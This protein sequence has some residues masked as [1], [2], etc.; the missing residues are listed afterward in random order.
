MAL[1]G[2]KKDRV[3]FETV[4]EAIGWYRQRGFFTG[5]TGTDAEVAAQ[6]E[7]RHDDEWDLDLDPEEEDFDMDLIEYDE[8]RAV[9]IDL[10]A[11]VCAGNDAYVEFLTAVAAVSR[12]RIVLDAVEERWPDDEHVELRVVVG[13]TEL[14]LTP[15]VRDDWLDVEPLVAVDQAAGG[16]GVL[17][18]ADTGG[19]DIFVLD[20]T[21]EEAH[22]LRRA[23]GWD[24]AG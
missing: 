1:F 4:A 24:L 8:R 21:P 2:R 9:R 7:R 20:L 6:L 15:A 18:L 17:H 3:E 10:E 22:E 14:H 13:G 12:G 16:P 11:D 23:R 5:F 19:Q